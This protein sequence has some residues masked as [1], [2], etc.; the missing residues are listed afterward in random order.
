[1]PPPSGAEEPP[2]FGR[3]VGSPGR[4]VLGA[5]GGTSAGSDGGFEGSAVTLA[6]SGTSIVGTGWSSLVGWLRIATSVT[7]VPMTTADTPPMASIDGP[8]LA[9]PLARGGGGGGTP[10]GICGDGL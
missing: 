9:R 6:G 2:V 4:L 10:Y 7:T 5:S 1:M 3:K 8:R